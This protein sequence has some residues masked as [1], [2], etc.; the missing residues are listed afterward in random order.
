MKKPPPQLPWLFVFG[1]GKHNTIRDVPCNLIKSFIHFRLLSLFYVYNTISEWR[2][3]R[4][5]LKR[6]AEEEV[7]LA[8]YYLHREHVRHYY[9][10][11]T[12]AI[13]GRNLSE[14]SNLNI[15]FPCY[16]KTR[17]V[18]YVDTHMMVLYFST[19]SVFTVHTYYY[20]DDC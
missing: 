8:I 14:I 20:D 12:R 2:F 13:T 7:N 11:N 5:V 19:K 10:H 4:C 6:G 18:K 16:R 15:D 9:Y 3:P 1:V 17:K